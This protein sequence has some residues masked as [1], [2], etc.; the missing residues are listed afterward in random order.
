V[1]RYIT[2]KIL[3]PLFAPETFKAKFRV[4]FTFTMALSTLSSFVIPVLSALLL[5]KRCLSSFFSPPDGDS[6]LVSETLCTADGFATN[7]C[8]GGNALTITFES[9]VV[10]PYHVDA[11]CPSGV[12]Q[13][14]R[15]PRVRMLKRAA[16]DAR[17]AVLCS[18]MPPS[19]C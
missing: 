7:N 2:R 15:K 14:C 12:V 11:T 3:V 5:D 10:H 4:V 18:C 9:R 17:R 13:V 1:A 8:T 19:G 16:S 6:V